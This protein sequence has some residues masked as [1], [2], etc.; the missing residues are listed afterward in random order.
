MSQEPTITLLVVSRHADPPEPSA[1]A[2]A[3]AAAGLGVVEYTP[4][5]TNDASPARGRTRLGAYSASVPDSPGASCRIVVARHDAAVATG[6]GEAAFNALA[7]GLAADDARTLREGTLALDMRLTAAPAQARQALAW[8]TALQRVLLDLT[9]GVVLDPTAQRCLGRA[10]IAAL[11]ANE[12]LAHVAFHDEPWSVESRWLH[13]HGVQKFGRPELDLV[14]VPLTLMDEANE[15]LRELAASLCAGASLAAGGLVDM[16]ELGMLVAVAAPVDV[17]HQAAYGRL[18]LADEPLPGEREPASPMRFLKRAALL[19][20]R[21]RLGAGD[22]GG[23]AEIVERVLAADPDDSGALDVKARLCLRSGQITDALDLGELMELR[24]PDDY[25]GP[26]IAGLALAALGR[27]REALRALER[28]VERE[29]EA[30]EAYA[31]RAEVR[32]RLGQEQL[33]A[34]DRARADYLRS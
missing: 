29:P 28:A 31:V 23:A 25:H 33:A 22:A 3:V 1:L 13:T 11:S 24:L 30:A 6:M 5:T 34:L 15:F 27:D 4:A 7:R 8:V 17:D 14:D 18:R 10:Q 2:R 12:P 21:H 16:D 20:A 26:L 32:E 9:G 19:E